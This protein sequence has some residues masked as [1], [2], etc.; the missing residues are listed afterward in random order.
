MYRFNTYFYV[1][2]DRADA[3]DTVP[4][5]CRLSYNQKKVVFSTGLRIESNKWHK[6]GQ[7]VKTITELDQQ[8]NRRLDQFKS[9]IHHHHYQLIEEGRGFNAED[10][11]NR[12]QQLE[13]PKTL[14]SMIEDHN[15]AMEKQIGVKYSKGTLKNYKTLI[16]HIKN[17]IKGNYT[18]DMPLVKVDKAFVYRFE[19]YLL[20]NTKCHQNGA[21]KVLQRLKK[22]TTIAKQ[23]EYI[24]KDPFEGY[25]FKFTKTQRTFLTLNELK[26]MSELKLKDDTLRW[27][28]K[29]FMFSS[30]T[31]L[32][33][34][35]SYN[36]HPSQIVQELN[37]IIWVKTSRQKTD[38]RSNVPLLEPALVY[39]TEPYSE[40]R[41]FKPLTNQCVN[42]GLKTIAALAGINKKITFHIARH[43]FATT[44][45]LNNNVPIETVSKMLGHSKIQT[46]QIYAK[47]LDK[48]VEN[49]MQKLNKKLL[50][51]GQTINQTTTQIIKRITQSNKS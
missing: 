1:I 20:E 40:E 37:D 39:I 51:N 14:I 35:D 11:K 24:E 42:R 46:T 32:S 15:M 12:M 10:I 5:Y 21:M 23:R 34:I 44:I 19:A 3:Q 31:G 38:N 33:Y 47:V 41:I 36:L 28:Q 22:I 9:M 6:K 17:F 45:T 50:K 26:S 49:D 7:F 2:D 18:I 48:K 43:T 8:I 27:I 29:M 4:I 30:Y 25:R 13:N 16:K